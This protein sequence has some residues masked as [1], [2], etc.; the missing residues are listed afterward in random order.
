[1]YF[2]LDVFSKGAKLLIN[3][4]EIEV[5]N[6]IRIKENGFIQSPPWVYYSIR[7][8]GTQA[9]AKD[10]KGRTPVGVRPFETDKQ[11]RTGRKT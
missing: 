2:N 11:N 6:T 4:N 10:R 9:F 8:G 7:F 3:N 1:M 5:K